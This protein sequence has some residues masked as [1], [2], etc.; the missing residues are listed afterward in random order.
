M[1]VI[2]NDTDIDGAINAATVDLDPATAGIQSTFTVSG[3]G[4]YAT[5][6]SGI[7][8]FT[9]VLNY[10]GIATPV[11]Y[12]VNDSGGATSNTATITI[13][14]TEENDTPVAIKMM[15]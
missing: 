8:T 15:Q 9:P 7:V 13:T 10:N 2:A 6:A 11:N 4:T 12:T 14:V 5:A 1:A 3:Q